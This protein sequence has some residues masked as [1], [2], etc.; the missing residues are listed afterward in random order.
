MGTMERQLGNMAIFIPLLSMLREHVADAEIV[1]SLQISDEFCQKNKLVS[2]KIKS[3]YEPT[4]KSGL[5]SLFDWGRSSLWRFIKNS[6]GV[7]LKWLLSGDKFRELLQADLILDFSGDTYGDVAHIEHLVKHSLD[8]L[9]FENLQIPLYLIAQSPGPFSGAFR[10]FLAKWV[11][12]R[13]T[14]ITCREGISVEYLRDLP[15]SRAPF[16]EAACPAWLLEPSEPVR[17]REIATIEKLAH[18]HHP[19][20]GFN[21]CGF[22]VAAELISQDKYRD[23]RAEEELL[24]LVRVIRYLL[25]DL[26]VNVVMIP[27]V[28]RLNAQSQMIPGPDGHITTQ[29]F[30]LVQ[31]QNPVNQDRL[32]VV[33]G[34]YRVDEIKGLIGRCDL[35]IAGRLHAGVAAMSQNIP[36]ILLAYGHKHYGFARQAGLEEYVCDNSRG[37][38]DADDIIAKVSQAWEQRETL[39]RVLARHMEIIRSKVVLN[40][41]LAREVAAQCHKGA[42]RL[43]ENSLTALQEWVEALNHEPAAE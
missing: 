7:D 15:V 28:Y 2:L 25:D 24:P 20:V 1:T 40:V 42:P 6:V 3:L 37:V 16:F 4:L 33:R 32:M 21:F 36:T 18:L 14:L 43:P 35:F 9:T 8:L 26:Q 30:D 22:N 11:L 31:A 5:I 29:L 38:I 23:L 39:S 12:N 10:R 19:L 34:T 13:V 27:H 41:A 17:T